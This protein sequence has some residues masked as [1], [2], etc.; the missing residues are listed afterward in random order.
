LSV[1]VASEDF[2]AVPV[3]AQLDPAADELQV[4]GAEPAAYLNAPAMLNL[5][6][7]WFAELTNR[8]LRPPLRDR[9]RSRRPRLDQRTEQEPPAFVWTKTADQILDT[10]AAYCQR[11]TDSGH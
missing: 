2:E 6:E 5:V 7:R 10:L 11:I 4:S 3:R 9:T 1:S 8:T